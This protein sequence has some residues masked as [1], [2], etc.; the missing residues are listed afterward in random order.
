[1]LPST[2]D[3]RMRSDAL[4]SIDEPAPIDDPTP[5]LQAACAYIVARLRYDFVSGKD[6]IVAYV[7]IAAPWSDSSYPPP[8][9]QGAITMYCAP[10]EN[11]VFAAL[12]EVLPIAAPDPEIRFFFKKVVIKDLYRGIFRICIRGDVTIPAV[13]TAA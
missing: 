4:V 13:L 5:T 11:A 6:T 10:L 8:P 1:M 3:K 12:K 2:E 7:D 9:A